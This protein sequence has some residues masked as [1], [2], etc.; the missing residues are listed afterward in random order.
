M[1]K[2]QTLFFVLGGFFI[3]NALVAELIGGKIIA[4]G[5]FAVS[6]GLLPWPIVFVATDLVNEFFGRRGVR[7]Y[8]FVTT[9]LIAYTFILLALARLAPTAGFSPITQ[10]AFDNVFGNS[11]WIIVGS[12]A[13]F[14]ASQFIDVLVFWKIRQKTGA[15]FLWARATGSTLVSQL[16]DTFVVAFIAFYLPG[17]LTLSQFLQVSLLSYLYKTVIAIAATPLCYAGHGLINRYLGL[18]EADHLAKQTA[19]Q[20]LQN[21]EP[22]LL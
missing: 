22:A 6:A 9:G 15:R 17:K 2:K 13:A 7:F 5:P 11:Q 20:A 1:N 10:T 16:I 8:T 3:T 19:A 18:S 12:L 14:L 21:L 4:V